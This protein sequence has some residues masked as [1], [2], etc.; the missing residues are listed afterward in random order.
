LYLHRKQ[1]QYANI[2]FERTPRKV[3]PTA[4]ALA[5]EPQA[6]IISEQLRLFMLSKGNLSA[7][8]FIEWNNNFVF[9]SETTPI[10]NLLSSPKGY[11]LFE[12]TPRKVIPTAAALALEPQARIISEQLRL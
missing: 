9:T 7:S 10:R 4:A 1:R 11:I 3:I 8:F 5:L 6:R 2:L 12:R